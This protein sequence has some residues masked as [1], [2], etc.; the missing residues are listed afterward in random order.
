MMSKEDVIVTQ[1]ISTFH[2]QKKYSRKNMYTKEISYVNKN[3]FKS[4]I[5]N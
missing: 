5:Y 1:N 2:V 4:N 3:D